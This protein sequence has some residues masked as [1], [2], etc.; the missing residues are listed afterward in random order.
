[1]R[2]LQQAETVNVQVLG[3]LRA[4]VITGELA[5]GTL[6]SVQSL[7]TQLGVSRTPVREALIKLAQQGM[8]RFERNRGVRVLQT[9][10]HDLEEVFTLRLLLEVPATRRAVAL[11]D[12]AGR[13]EL[14]KQLQGMERAAAADD[15]Y[16]LWEHD[17]RFHRLLIAASGNGRLAEYVD[18][19]RDMVLRSGVSTAGSSRSLDA[20]VAEHAAVLILVEA[21]DAEGAAAAMRAHLLH[22]A[23]LLIRQEAGAE[24]VGVDLD[25]GWTSPGGQGEG[26]TPD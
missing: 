21:G 1:M 7:A 10:V 4:A 12:A 18:G 3:A 8:V 14:R 6:H 22:T 5:P 2:L 11:L 15:E 24:A 20:I 16:R 13:R 25:M 17:R 26:P 9:S 19:L 23:E